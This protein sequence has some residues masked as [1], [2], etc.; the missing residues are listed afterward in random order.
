MG[1]DIHGVIEVKKDGRWI[2]CEDI[3]DLFSGRY[4]PFF[5][6]FWGERR[7]KDDLLPPLFPQRG[8]PT[9]ASETIMEDL[10]DYFEECPDTDIKQAYCRFSYF[11]LAELDE[12]LTD[13][14]LEKPFRQTVKKYRIKKGNCNEIL[15]ES[16]LLIEELTE[17][18]KKIFHEKGYIL[19][20][21]IMY[22]KYVETVRDI[23]ECVYVNEGI[24]IMRKLSEKYKPTDIR[25]VVDF[26]S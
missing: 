15:G 23:A 22:E 21:G 13:E 6:L 2:A 8:L 26:D 4:Y 5:S 12:I 16:W 1:C 20:E 10:R 14:F 19:I 18:Q 25:L 3:H 7:D 17:P 11:T 24:D 9:D